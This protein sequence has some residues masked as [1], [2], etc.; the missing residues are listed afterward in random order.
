MEWGGLAKQWSDGAVIA[1]L[2][3]WVALSIAFVA[4][5][6]FQGEYAI[7]PLRMLKPRPFWSHLLYAWM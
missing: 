3:L 4:I 5:E 7:M 2:A 6:W 1:T